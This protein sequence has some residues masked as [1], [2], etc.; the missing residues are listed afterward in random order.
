MISI[1]ANILL[2]SY[3]AESPYHAAARP[4]LE[5]ISASEEV[6]LSEEAIEAAIE[7]NLPLQLY[8]PILLES[9]IDRPA[10]LVAQADN[11]TGSSSSDSLQFLSADCGVILSFL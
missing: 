6:A 11:S 10:E 2:Y 9:P 5:G 1:D 7:P 3:C 4:F 8:A